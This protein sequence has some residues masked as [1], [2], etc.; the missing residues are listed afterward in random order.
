MADREV[1]AG[2]NVEVGCNLGECCDQSVFGPSRIDDLLIVPSAKQFAFVG[3][4]LTEDLAETVM[5]IH[6]S[7]Q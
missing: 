6:S 5:A 2:G 1:A 3:D 4:V 7:N